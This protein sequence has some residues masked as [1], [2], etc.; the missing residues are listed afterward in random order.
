[1]HQGLA[2]K[3]DAGID[4]RAIRC[5]EIY[6]FPWRFGKL[7]FL[8]KFYA[9]PAMLQEVWLESPFCGKPVVPSVLDHPLRE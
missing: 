4:F 7:S 5:H 9:W 6:G 8:Q 2:T 3:A 1:L